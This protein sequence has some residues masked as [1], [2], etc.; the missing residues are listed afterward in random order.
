MKNDNSN[1]IPFPE[2]DD[3]SGLKLILEYTRDEAN[4]IGLPLVVNLC[5]MA[6]MS[7]DLYAKTNDRTTSLNENA[8][9]VWELTHRSDA[10]AKE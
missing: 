8:N 7:L 10:D 2:L 1:S 6:A 5:V 9:N 3:L 4:Q